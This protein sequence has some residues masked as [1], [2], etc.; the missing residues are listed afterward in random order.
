M[1]TDPD[2]LVQISAKIANLEAQIVRKRA[3]QAKASSALKEARKRTTEGKKKYSDDT[4]RKIL[5]GAVLL[6]CL[7]RGELDEASFRNLMSE[8]LTR[9]SDRA[10]FDL[11]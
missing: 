2:R 1:P 8:N 4:R 9:E 6:G 10:L 11:D 5:A 7:E 3:D